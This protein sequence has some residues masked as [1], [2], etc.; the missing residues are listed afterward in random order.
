MEIKMG[1]QATD[2][3]I[4]LANGDLRI[5]HVFGD[6]KEPLADDH[7]SWRLDVRTTGGYAFGFQME[8]CNVAWVREVIEPD[9]RRLLSW[10]KP[11]VNPLG[12]LNVP[13]QIFLDQVLLDAYPHVV[14]AQ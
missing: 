13:Q 11:S 6:R 4:K 7:I 2:L 8:G 14:T 10:D 5:T 12:D 9:G 3:L 1:K